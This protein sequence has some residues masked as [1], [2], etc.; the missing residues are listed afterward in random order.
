MSEP[1]F[2][3]TPIKLGGVEYVM[4]PLNLKR[5]KALRAEFDI[6]NTM[7]KGRIMTDEQIDAMLK[8][9]HAAISRN[10]PDMTVDDL[11]ELIDFGNLQT[12]SA[13]VSSI[14]GLVQRGE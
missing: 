12:I 5:L 14:S 9:I 11:A 10:Y 3:G 13:A 2:E 7:D 8:V 4:P 1:K 6:V